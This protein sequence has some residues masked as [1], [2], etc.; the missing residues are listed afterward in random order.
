MFLGVHPEGSTPKW[1]NIVIGRQASLGATRP[2]PVLLPTRWDRPNRSW[3]VR[4]KRAAPQGESGM[5]R[6]RKWSKDESRAGGRAERIEVEHEKVE[7]GRKGSQK[8]RGQRDGGSEGARE[9]I[10]AEG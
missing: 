7:S 10:T 5:D 4:Q 9:E 1:R 3:A 8:Q 2:G 6:G